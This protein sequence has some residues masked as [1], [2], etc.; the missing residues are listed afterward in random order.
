[1]NN[2]SNHNDQLPKALW[3]WDNH[4]RLSLTAGMLVWL[5]G[6]VVVVLCSG[7]FVDKHMPS[8]WVLGGFVVSHLV[9]FGLGAAKS[10]TVR[11]GF[12]SLMHVLCW[13]PGFV[14]VIL[15][16]DG[17]QESLL[18][19]YWSWVLVAVLVVSLAFDLRDSFTY[20]VHVIRNAL[21]DAK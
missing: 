17:R 20:L 21:P 14:A 4:A 13:S 1:M 2:R 9:V 18:Y 19:E 15:D 8:R 11:R 7:F 3:V 10:F 16:R 6:L 5:G 12:V